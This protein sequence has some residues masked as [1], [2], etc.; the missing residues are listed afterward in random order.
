MNDESA[1]LL[2]TVLWVFEVIRTNKRAVVQRIAE[3]Y[4]EAQRLVATIPKEDGSARP[5]IVACFARWSVY[6]DKDDLAGTGWILTAIQE[7]IAEGD[8]PD[9]AAI[10]ILIDQAVAMLPNPKRL[11]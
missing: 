11:H 6:R 8:L 1:D 4:A 5:R 2:Q 10:K 9:S 7:R 3:T